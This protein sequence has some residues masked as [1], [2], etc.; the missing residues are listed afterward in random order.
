MPFL[1]LSFPGKGEDEEI[2]WDNFSVLCYFRISSLYFFKKKASE[3]YVPTQSWGKIPFR[4][5]HSL[6]KPMKL[7][8]HGDQYSYC[9]TAPI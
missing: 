6:I 2:D 9:Q 3:D 8:L 7:I 4:R 5:F 1:M